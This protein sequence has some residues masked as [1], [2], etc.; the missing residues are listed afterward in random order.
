MNEKNATDEIEPGQTYVIDLFRPADA[1]GV[2]TLFKTVYGEGYPIRTFI[3]PELLIQEN[4]AHRT[5]SIVARTPKGDIVGHN[6]LF[7]SAPYD[8]I[9]EAGAGVVHPHYRGGKGIFTQMI[10]HGFKVGAEQ[11]GLE[12]VFGEPV[13]NHLFSQM[14]TVTVRAITQ[15]VEVD[16]MPAAAYQ[17]EKSAAGRVTTLLDFMLFKPKE[18]TLYLPKAYAESLKFIYG[19]LNEKRTLRL[20][21]EGLLPSLKSVIKT[22][23]FDFAQVARLAVHEAGDDFP[24]VLEQEEQAVL[25]K[26]VLVIQIWVNLSWPWVG[27][28]VDF[29]RQRGYFLGG[30]LPRWFDT[31]GL[32]MQKIIETPNWDGIQL[33]TDNAKEILK[34]IKTDWQETQR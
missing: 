11:F 9:Y 29:L 22:R 18:Q 14:A 23:V 25:A 5:I 13:C 12:A 19:F 4:A 34:R 30:P 1:A 20:S 3:Q 7:N 27:R 21:D 17:Q 15:A 26:G 32:L 33:Y 28:V 8:R 10:K 31:D 24:A 6:A 16:L 2:T